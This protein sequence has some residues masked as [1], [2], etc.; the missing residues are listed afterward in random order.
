MEAL[1]LENYSIPN[2]QFE[3]GV[4]IPERLADSK[5]GSLVKELDSWNKIVR[6]FQEVAG[7]E[8]REYYVKLKF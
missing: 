7:D 6:G 8:E 1:N 2:G 3:V 4:L 5:L